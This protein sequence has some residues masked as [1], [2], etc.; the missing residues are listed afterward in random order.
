VSTFEY[1]AIAAIACPIGIVAIVLAAV[2]FLAWKPDDG[3]LA[4]D[5]PTEDTQD[6]TEAVD[7]I[8]AV[9]PPV[10]PAYIPPAGMV[11]Y[12]GGAV[13]PACA[14][15]WLRDDVP[16]VDGCAVWLTDSLKETV[17]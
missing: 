11:L 10:V 15:G 14:R 4:S 5:D 12:R 6:L 17:T 13:H 1:A 3:P 9:D 16:P 7:E 8:L 2:L